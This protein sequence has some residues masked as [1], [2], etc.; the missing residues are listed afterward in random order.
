LFDVDPPTNSFLLFGVVTSVPLLA[1]IDQEMRPRECEQTDR[2][3]DRETDTRCD[4]QRQT[5]FIICPVLCGI[6]MKQMII[7]IFII[8][9]VYG[10]VIMNMAIVRV[11][12]AF[13]ELY[14][15]K[16]NCV[17]SN[18]GLSSALIETEICTSIKYL[19]Y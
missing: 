8:V 10:T 4:R 9:D 2:Q 6:A 14:I 16:H 18:A 3:T 5:E 15:N 12:R 11:H 1:K 17:L 7:I 19:A 13:D